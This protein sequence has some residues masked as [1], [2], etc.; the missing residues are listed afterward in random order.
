MNLIITI[1]AYN[2]EAT[3]ASVITRIPRNCADEVKILVIDDG[4]TDNTAA[5]AVEAGA[6]KIVSHGFNKGLGTAFQTGI[7]TALEMG[8][9]VVVNIDADGQFNPEDI[10]KL[11]EPIKENEADMVTCTRFLE[12][13]SSF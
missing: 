10:P 7:E 5:V 1:P 8:A 2:E 3:I 4:S 12:K 9:D 11:I 13:E 6:D